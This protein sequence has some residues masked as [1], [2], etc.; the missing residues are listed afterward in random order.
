MLFFTENEINVLTNNLSVHG[1]KTDVNTYNKLLKNIRSSQVYS[2][3]NNN[4]Y[5]YNNSNNSNRRTIDDSCPNCHGTGR[6]SMCAGRGEWQ[7][8]NGKY[9]D[10]DVCHGGGRCPSCH[11]SG[12]LR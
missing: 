9:Y 1:I 2:S 12:K 10:C 7:G 6:C 3:P 5:D 11:G 8:S 4:G